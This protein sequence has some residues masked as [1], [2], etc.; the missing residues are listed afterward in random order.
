MILTKTQ[1]EYTFELNQRKIPEVSETLELLEKFGLID[2]KVK[3]GLLGLVRSLQTE[4]LSRSSFES[5]FISAKKLSTPEFSLEVEQW[6]KQYSLI[7]FLETFCSPD[8]KYTVNEFGYNE[9]LDRFV[10]S[11]TLEFK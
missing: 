6:L 8:L 9:T 3:P 10:A 11:F 2:S 7:E 4:I 1:I 5:P